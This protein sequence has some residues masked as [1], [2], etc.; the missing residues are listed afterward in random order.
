MRAD[1]RRNRQLALAAA[2]ELYADASRQ[3]QMDDIAACAGVGVGTVYRHFPTKEALM[4]ELVRERF[5]TFAENTRGALASDGEPFSAFADLLRRN[6]E[7]MAHDAA[8]RHALSGAG[9]EVWTYAA[10]ERDT[11]LALAAELVAAAHRAGTLR[12]DFTAGDIPMLMCGVCATMGDSGFDW[13]RHLELL[14]DGL[15]AR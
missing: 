15:R 3:V 14:L 1:A 13:R 4:G 6:A 12:A 7:H 11:L 10:T 9:E 5:A 2:R 8:T